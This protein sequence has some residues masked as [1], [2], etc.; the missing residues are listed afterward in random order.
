[1]LMSN[2]VM[3]VDWPIPL[4]SHVTINN[5]VTNIKTAACITHL[6][7]LF[8]HLHTVHDNVNTYICI[9]FFYIFRPKKV[10]IFSI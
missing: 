9:F 5:I 2:D 6:D 3:D 8:P 10:Y 1:M 7:Y 4:S